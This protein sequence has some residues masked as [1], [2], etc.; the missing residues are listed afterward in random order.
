MNPNYIYENIDELWPTFTK[1]NNQLIIATPITKK[2]SNKWQFSWRE[3]IL[4]KICPP[5]IKILTLEFDD[6]FLKR[7]SISY[8]SKKGYF[9]F[10]GLM[11]KDLCE[12][13]PENSICLVMDIDAYPL[14]SEAIK[15]TFLMTGKKEFYGNLQRTNC[16]DNNAHLFVVASYMCFQNKKIKSFGEE[17]FI[18]NERS[19]PGEEIFWQLPDTIIEDQLRP[20]KTIFAPIWPLEGNKSVY[21][22]GTTFGYKKI[23]IN[24]HHFLSRSAIGK[25]HFFII[26]FAYYFIL[27]TKDIKRLRNPSLV[28]KLIRNF[29][30]ELS[31]SI[32]YIFNKVE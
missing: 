4:R 26:S 24:Y 18:A 6:Y 19:E 22:I 27:K 25:L 29:Y 31:Y 5:E 9:N 15:F 21:G 14:S 2:L 1:E 13:I 12:L 20:I 30:H 16:I 17:A 28:L 10:H 11:L 8:Q 32:K 23:P 3:K 7:K